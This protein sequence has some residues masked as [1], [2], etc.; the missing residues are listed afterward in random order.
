MTT[1]FLLAVEEF[2]TQRDQTDINARNIVVVPL[3][4]KL[5][6]SYDSKD[7][8]KTLTGIAIKIASSNPELKEVTKENF[9]EEHKYIC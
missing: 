5:L 1:I 3:I 7:A 6:S 9:K 2:G 8:I 4:M